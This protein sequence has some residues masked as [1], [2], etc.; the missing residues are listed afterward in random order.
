MP[1]CQNVGEY[2]PL[3]YFPIVGKNYRLEVKAPNF[4]KVFAESSIPINC[5]VQNFTCELPAGFAPDDS[6][7]PNSSV[8]LT[9]DDDP[10]KRNF[11]ELHFVF[12]DNINA[13]TWGFGSSPTST[14]NLSSIVKFN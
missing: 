9:F 12:G 10:N 6:G 1:S 14:Y 11:H 5:V 13:T 3:Y 8:L 4:D 2:F 7:Q